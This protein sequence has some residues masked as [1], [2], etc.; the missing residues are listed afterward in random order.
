MKKHLENMKIYIRYFGENYCWLNDQNYGGEYKRLF[1]LDK[2][3]N[4]Q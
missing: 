4:N 1:F 3:K 2:D